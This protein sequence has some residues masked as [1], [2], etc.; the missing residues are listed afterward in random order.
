MKMCFLCY[1]PLPNSGRLLV[2]CHIILLPNLLEI[3]KMYMCR[4]FIQL[5]G[6]WYNFSV[7]MQISS[8]CFCLLYIYIYIYSLHV[9][10]YLA[11]FRY[12]SLFCA[13]G[14]YKG[15][16]TATDSLGLY[17]I[18]MQGESEF[19]NTNILM[20]ASCQNERKCY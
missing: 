13:V 5:S 19:N 14:L 17:C 7:Y 12:P 6:F 15:S 8:L 3:N 2:V 1:M 16:P 4:Q 10:A 18:T 11:I 20:T 9:L